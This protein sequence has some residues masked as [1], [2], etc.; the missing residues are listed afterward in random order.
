MAQ[1]SA[2]ILSKSIDYHDPQGV[3]PKFQATLDITLQ[4]PE[5]PSRHSMV[6]IDKPNQFFRLVEIKGNTSIERQL[7][8]GDCK[9]SLNGKSEF[10]QEEKEKHK[11]TCDRT[12]MYRDYYTYLYGLPMKLE[13]E[14]AQLDS[15]APLT[16]FQ[17]KEYYRLKVTYAGEVG[18]D[19]WYFYINPTNYAL[20]AYQFYHDE[21][22][23]DG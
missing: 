4:M 13:D 15:L 23:N 12:K 10:T 16:K 11:L 21:S 2:S 19:I 7:D 5:G 1:N 9:I 3:W 8:K 14:G 6:T 20:E 17:D 18:S 22:A